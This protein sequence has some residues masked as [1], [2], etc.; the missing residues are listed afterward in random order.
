MNQKT[1]LKF[2][3]ASNFLERHP[4]F[5]DKFKDCLHHYMVKVDKKCRTK[6]SIVVYSDEAGYDDWFNRFSK[7]GDTR[8]DDPV[9]VPF[10]DY[11]GEP[12]K[13]HH[14]MVEMEISIPIPYLYDNVIAV[15]YTRGND[16][17]VSGN[18]FEECLV[19]LGE[20]VKKFYGDYPAKYL[21][22]KWVK[23]NNK[24]KELFDGDF[25]LNKDYITFSPI[26]L[27]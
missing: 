21:Q 17:D 25:T 24:D 11:Y 26:E 3:K 15:M 6:D 9:E 20:R 7:E 18:S 14:V 12:W 16:L 5:M 2:I 4:V 8:G 27:V 10:V 13:F 19:T 22:P 1:M 23:K